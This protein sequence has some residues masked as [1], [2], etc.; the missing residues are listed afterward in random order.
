MPLCAKY[1]KIY[2][3]ETLIFYPPFGIYFATNTINI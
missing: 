2:E 1:K 3:H